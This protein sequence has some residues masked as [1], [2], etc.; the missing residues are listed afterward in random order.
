MLAG[1]EKPLDSEKLFLIF[2]DEFSFYHTPTLTELLRLGRAY[3]MGLVLSHQNVEDLPVELEAAAFGN[4]ATTVAF[5]VG[6]T[7][8]TKLSFHFGAKIEGTDFIKTPLYK[9]YTK[10]ETDVFTMDTLPPPEID[11]GQAE[12]IIERSREKLTPKPEVYRE[13]DEWEG[14]EWTEPLITEEPADKI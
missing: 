1:L 13:K 2:A 7:Y 14:V 11:K 12:R 5:R 9:T 10:V 8:A 3:K 4:I 6:S